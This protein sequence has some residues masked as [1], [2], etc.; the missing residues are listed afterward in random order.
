MTDKTGSSSAKSSSRNRRLGSRVTSTQSGLTLFIL[1]LGLAIG[2]ILITAAMPRARFETK[3]AKELDLIS[4]GQ[5]VAAGIER[6]R[7]TTNRY[8]ISMDELVT[9]VTVGI[10]Q[11]HF[12]RPSAAKD[13]MTND[14]WRLVRPGD[15]VILEFAEAWQAYTLQP[16][17]ASM[18]ALI[19]AQVTLPGQSTGTPGQTGTTQTQGTTFGG[20]IGPFIA[21]VS[22]SKEQS[23]K[24]YFGLDSY[25]KWLFINMPAA[26]TVPGVPIVPL[27]QGIPGNP[28]TGPGGPG[29]NPG[30]GN[31]GG[32]G[33]TRGGG[34][35]GN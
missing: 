8:P 30:G 9:G 20:D 26:S 14:E 33:P 16:L 6:F 34:R 21:V 11:L 10:R 35:S 5:Q 13:P 24:L 28:V 25:D 27:Q 22:S 15:P 1:I 31:P 3:R 4:K 2:M 17:P 32:G 23:A 12:V 29:G 7:A 18:Q 19:G